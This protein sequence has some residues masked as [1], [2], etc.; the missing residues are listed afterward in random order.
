LKHRTSAAA[1]WFCGGSAACGLI[2]RQ[3]NVLLL[4]ALLVAL[5]L[6]KATVAE[7]LRLWTLPL[8]GGLMI[9]SYNLYVL[10]HISGGHTVNGLNGS[11]LDGFAGILFSP[12]RGLFIYTP[13][14]IFA[15][16]ALLPSAAAARAKHAPLL[17]ACLVFVVLDSIV[18][19]KWGVWWGGYCWGPR[20]LTE[21]APP[22]TVLMAIGV[23]AIQRPWPRRAFA[24]LALYSISIQAIGAFFYPKGHWDTRPK[25]VNA[26]R[27]R[28]WDWRDNPI[29][30]TVGAGPAWESYAVIGTAIAGGLPAAQRRMRELNAN[31]YDESP[32]EGVP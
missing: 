17:A 29:A 10:R 30:R 20:L 4:P 18:I 5:L 13:V 12:G 2:F 28:L 16:Y 6:S 15:L 14:A 1:L 9:A 3:T 21:L 8:L 22:L 19:A 7:H 23:S 31:P 24:V 27:A 26:A 11:L 25:N 32:P